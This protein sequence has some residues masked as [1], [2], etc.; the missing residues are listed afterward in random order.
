MDQIT[1]FFRANVEWI[2]LPATGDGGAQGRKMLDYACGNGVASMVGEA[3]V[4]LWS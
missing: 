2:G 1:E 4:A 3:R